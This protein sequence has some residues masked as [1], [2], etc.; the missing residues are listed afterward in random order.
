MDLWISL[1]I[2]LTSLFL[3]T[4]NK[5]FNSINVSVTTD[6]SWTG[7]DPN[8]DDVVYDVYF[9]T[10]SPSLKSSSNQSAKTYNL[11]EFDYETE[12][13]WKIIAWD[14][15]GKYAEGATWEFITIE[16]NDSPDIPSIGGIL[17]GKTET[18]YEYTFVTTDP[19]RD[20]VYYYIEWGDGSNSGEWIGPFISGEETSQMHTW[21]T[22]GEYTIRVKAKDIFGA[23]SDWGTLEVSMPR[24][25][26]FFTSS[27][28]L[29][30][31]RL[32]ERCPLLEQL[33]SFYE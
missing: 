2:C 26:P 19:N 11:G 4:G 25:K 1:I 18:E 29:F 14:A 9:G 23:E 17:S 31:E 12:Y 13:Y 16:P 33:I 3:G 6:L 15:Y 5:N 27:F 10:S 21:E 8:S 22:K 32:F 20:D 30:F 7:G 24:T 28:S